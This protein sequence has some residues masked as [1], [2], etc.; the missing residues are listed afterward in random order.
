MTRVL[1]RQMEENRKEVVEVPSVSRSSSCAAPPS[2]VEHK[3]DEML[4][5]HA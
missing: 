4:V 2:L 1:C 5:L 3:V